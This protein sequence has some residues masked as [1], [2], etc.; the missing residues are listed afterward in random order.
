LIE[1]LIELALE[2]HEQR[3]ALKFTFR[4]KPGATS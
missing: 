1:R 4:P 2:D 3:A